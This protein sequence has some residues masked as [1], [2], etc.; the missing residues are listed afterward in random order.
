MVFGCPRVSPEWEL[1]TLHALMKP[2]PATRGAV[3]HRNGEQPWPAAADAILARTLAEVA[4]RLGTALDVHRPVAGEYH[5]LAGF[6]PEQQPEVQALAA[7]LSAR[8]PHLWFVVDRL[9]VQGGVFHR[10]QFGYKLNLVPATNV[11]LTRPIR[12]ALRGVI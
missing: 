5:F 11:H 2:K 6:T 4:E 9:Y 12:A 7:V 8:L 10:R 1:G 3:E